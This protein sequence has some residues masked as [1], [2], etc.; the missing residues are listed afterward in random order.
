VTSGGLTGR[1]P[2]PVVAAFIAILLLTSA[3]GSGA[4]K[5]GLPVY[6][7]PRPTPQAVRSDVKEF[8]AGDHEKAVG[9]LT[10]Y[11]TTKRNVDILSG[12][13][14]AT[15]PHDLSPAVVVYTRVV[16]MHAHRQPGSGSTPPGERTEIY[17]SD[18]GLSTDANTQTSGVGPFPPT[19][20]PPGMGQPTVISA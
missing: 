18:N 7:P 3:C 11:Y 19:S 1:R 16:N 5:T 20:L 2:G 6:H 4:S 9:E 8:L 13:S 12:A 14:P 10:I 17:F 15:A